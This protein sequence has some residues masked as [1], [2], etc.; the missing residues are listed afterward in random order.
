MKPNRFRVRGELETKPWKEIKHLT[1]EIAEHAEALMGQGRE[2]TDPFPKVS[3][4][5]NRGRT[6]MK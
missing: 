1:A 3:G 2:K 5:R 4:G 6:F